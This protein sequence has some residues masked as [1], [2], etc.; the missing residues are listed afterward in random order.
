[1]IPWE[2]FDRAVTRWKIRQ[3]TGGEPAAPEVEATGAV[4]QEMMDPGIDGGYTVEGEESSSGLIAIGDGDEV[5]E[6]PD[7]EAR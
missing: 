3:A 7:P 5:M 1:M 4:I 2:E 6:E